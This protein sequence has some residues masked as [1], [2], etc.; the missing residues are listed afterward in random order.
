MAFGH[1]MKQPQNKV[2]R[3]TIALY[4]ENHF[5]TYS[6]LTMTVFEN[7]MLNNPS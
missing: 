7:S 4:L 2:S 3:M 1:Y 6:N 5:A